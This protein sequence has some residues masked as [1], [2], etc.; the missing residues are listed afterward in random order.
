MIPH[1]G[2]PDGPSG[3]TIPVLPLAPSETVA[4]NSWAGTADGAGEAVSPRSV[5]GL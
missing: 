3:E 2:G 4:P 1:S 5:N